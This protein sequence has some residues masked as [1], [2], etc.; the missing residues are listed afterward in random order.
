MKATALITGASSGIGKELARC[1]ARAG[2]NLV[3]TARRDEALQQLKAELEDEYDSDVVCIATD[4]TDRGSPKQVYDQLQK[5]HVTIDA[6]INNAGFGGH[7]LFYERDWAKDRAMIE[8]NVMA[9]TELCHLFLPGMVARGRG[10]ILNVASTAGFMPGPM[11]AVYYATKAYVLSLSQ[12]IAEELRN[13]DVTV[14][15]L[16]PGPVATEFAEVGNLEDVPAF[17]DPASPKAVAEVGYEAMQKGK[18]VAINDAKLS[19]AINWLIPLM[20]RK[21]VLKLSRKS[22]QKP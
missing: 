3:I 9:V 1:H 4:L 20:P 14:T 7:G 6:L 10:R 15:A 8:L 2:G 22:M 11:Q 19:F 12:A 21:L 18:L 13:T 16:C 17:K 5:Q